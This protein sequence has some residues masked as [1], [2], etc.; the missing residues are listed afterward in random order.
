[1]NFIFNQKKKKKKKKKKKS[2]G[3]VFFE[4]FYQFSTGMERIDVLTNL[5][6]KEIVFPKKFED[7][8][9]EKQANLIRWMLNYDPDQRPTFF[10]LFFFFFFFLLF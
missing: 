4:L 5:R 9:F 2:L 3:I 7:P 6:K 10:F 8:K 1:L